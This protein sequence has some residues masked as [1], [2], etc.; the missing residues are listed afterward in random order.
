M[1]ITL[2][3]CKTQINTNTDPDSF[4]MN[5]VWIILLLLLIGFIINF[6]FIVWQLILWIKQKG[7]IDHKM[8]LNHKS[9]T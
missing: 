4:I 8:Y 7:V 2:I 1:T 9:K 3:I 5:L 6:P